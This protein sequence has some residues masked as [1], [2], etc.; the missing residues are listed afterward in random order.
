MMKAF[1]RARPVTK[2]FI[3]HQNPVSTFPAKQNFLLVEK[4]HLSSLHVGEVCITRA[5]SIERA[6]ISAA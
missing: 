2:F 4:I 6:S 3:G 5:A 1:I